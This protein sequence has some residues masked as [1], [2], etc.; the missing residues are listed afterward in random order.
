MFVDGVSCGGG[1]FWVMSAID[2]AIYMAMMLHVAG[3]GVICVV[4]VVLL[5]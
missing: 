2:L 5:V 1:H 4:V 3:V